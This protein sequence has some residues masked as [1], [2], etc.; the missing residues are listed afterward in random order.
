MIFK[1]LTANFLQYQ[2]ETYFYPLVILITSILRYIKKRFALKNNLYR[3]LSPVVFLIFLIACSTKKDT[4][5]SRNSHAL[6][7]RDNILFNGNIALTN[8]LQDVVLQNVDNFWERLPIERMQVTEEQLEPEQNRNANFEKAETKATKAIQKH[9]MY[10]QGSE[11]N[12]QMDEAHLML[13]KARYYDQRFL[14][15]LE[16]FNYVLYKYPSSNKIYEVK[17]WREKTNIRL[18]NDGLAVNNLQKLLRE[19]KFKNQVYADA[20]A[21][22]AQA[23][24]NLEE[25]D[26]AIAR[27]K[28]A[29]A[30]TKSNEEKSRYRFI[31][32]QVYEEIGETD[33]AYAYY[34]KVIDMKRKAGRQYV[35]HAHLRQAGQFDYKRG[36]GEAFVLKYNEL[37]A[38]RENRP[39]RDFLN[40][41]LGLYFD[42]QKNGRVAGRYYNESLNYALNNKPQDAYLIASNYRNLGEINFNAAQ[43]VTAGKYYDSTLVYLKPRTREHN[44][45]KKKRENL[46]DVIKYE[47]I[48]RTNDS[49]LSLYNMSDADKKAYF[50]A[51]VTQL[52]GKEKEA[53]AK[54]EKEA[55]IKEFQ[56]QNAANA[57]AQ[58]KGG[59]KNPANIPGA[60]SDFYFYNPSTV[61][62]GKNQF[63]KNWGKRKL[64]DRWRIIMTT[65]NLS[66]T[67]AEAKKVDTLTGTKQPAKVDEK[68]T[69]DYYIKQIPESKEFIDSINIER[70][71]AYYQLGIIYK[72]KFKEYKLA[73]AKLE[74]LLQN[75]PEEKLVLPS[76]YHLYKLYGILDKKKAEEMKSQ[77][78]SQ[79][80][81]SRYAQILNNPNEAVAEGINSPN[82]AYDALFK[83]YQKGDMKAVLPKI[84][85]AIDTYNGEEIIPKLELLKANIIGKLKGLEEYKAAL[86]YVAL[87]YPNVEEGKM[88]DKLL[89]VSIPKME[90]LQLGKYPSKSWKILYQT[91]DFEDKNTKILRQKI[92]KFIKDRGL[93][94]LSVSLDVYTMTDNFVVI[95]GLNTEDLADGIVSILKDY[96][97]YKIQDKAIIISSE[98]YTII[99]IK[100]NLEEYLAGNL[101]ENPKMPNWEGELEKAPETD[102]QK[103]KEI[104]SSRTTTAPQE[105]IKPMN[106][107]PMMPPGGD[108]GLPPSPQQMGQ[109]VK[110]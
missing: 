79:Y 73:T 16:A 33:S 18:E 63:V 42:K 72:E 5:V 105:Q 31:L 43:Y 2:K 40:Y 56:E 81:D 21:A 15:A 12:P 89:T 86:N 74:Q 48:A 34:Q 22:L 106:N 41:Q 50:D 11:K 51:Y 9:S 90:A 32:G 93:E 19:I 39:Y 77:I 57:A 38:D 62:Y 91:K 78:I 98:N 59:G 65:D 95:H 104:K 28:I 71:F 20:N 101:A 109:P 30:F 6:S 3:Y 1:K 46:D 60:P 25:Q 10:I 14:P 61:A 107:A 4:W 80:P 44:L 84:E 100:K 54:A 47:G 23:F 69:S 102:Q 88:A 8:G 108:M 24:L 49:I 55:R 29:T 70:N 17:I 94:K 67:P 99:Q 45:Y 66:E 83:E 13:G 64:Q 103:P 97:D 58:P 53:K 75:N 87:N 82:A 52:A 37:L 96:K 7:T 68:L 35:I 85:E 27:L 92:D 26:S 110:R 36:D 76:M